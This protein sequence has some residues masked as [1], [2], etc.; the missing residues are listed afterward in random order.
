LAKRGV[1]K[2]VDFPVNVDAGS[3][4]FQNGA[5]M[6]FEGTL[7]NSAEECIASPQDRGRLRKAFVEHYT[8][9]WC[10]L[11][12][13]GVSAHGADDAAQQVFLIALEALPRIT[14][15]SER[16]FLYGT[17]VR[18]AHGLRRRREREVGGVD[19]DL[20]GSALLGPDE[21]TDQKRTREALDRILERMDLD[22][23]T[24]FVL[25]EIEGFTVP[26]IAKVLALPVGTAAS[27]LRRSR[28]H[29]Q[30]LVRT[31]VGRK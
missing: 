27:R 17:A 11:R 26:E 18:T 28:E 7:A 6:L 29:F 13:M 24:V 20:A 19:V 9:I 15:G 5:T 1:K 30:S 3:I 31:H 4:L 25:F 16:A 10:F 14:F 8:G 12:R 23:R 22:L 21:L 2:W